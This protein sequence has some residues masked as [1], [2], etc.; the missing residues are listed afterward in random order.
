MD[1]CSATLLALFQPRAGFSKAGQ[2]RASARGLLFVNEV[3]TKH[4]AVIKGACINGMRG[5]KGT[6]LPLMYDSQR[7]FIPW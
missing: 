5:E 6:R 3:I 1:P 7:A 2:P 4:S